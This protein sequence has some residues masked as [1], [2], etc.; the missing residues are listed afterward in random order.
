VSAFPQVPGCNGPVSTK[1]IE[2]ICVEFAQDIKLPVTLMVPPRG[3]LDGDI[4]IVT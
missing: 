3:T 4:V 2:T 1:S